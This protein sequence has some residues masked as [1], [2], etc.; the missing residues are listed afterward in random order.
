MDRG[1]KAILGVAAA[2]VAIAYFAI[3]GFPEIDLKSPISVKLFVETDLSVRI[4]PELKPLPETAVPIAEVMQ[5]PHPTFEEYVE[6][7]RSLGTLLQRD[8]FLK[9]M[10]GKTLEWEG[11]VTAVSERSLGF[12]VSI[13]RVDS[14]PSFR[15]S[16][17][18]MLSFG[19]GYR[20]RLL[21]LDVGTVINV[22]C[23]FERYFLGPSLENCELL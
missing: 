20:E 5:N 6:E 1:S 2:V 10:E 14:D 8:T 17:N 22:R 16:E 18:A 11:R 15:L 3:F 9:E 13:D 19:L 4:E 12:F 23:T 7:W 21:K